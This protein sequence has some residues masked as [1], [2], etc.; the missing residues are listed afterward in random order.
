MNILFT[1]QNESLRMFDALR[2]AIAAKRSIHRVGF[3]VADRAFYEEWLRDR[4]DF[5]RRGHCLL[6]EWEVTAARDETPDLDRLAR[7]E[8]DLGAEAGLFGALVADRRLFMGSDCSFTQDYRRR[9]SDRQ[10][11]AIL[12][13]GLI[14]TERLFDELKPDVL[15]GFICVTMLDYLAYLFARQRGIRVLNLRPTRIANR[16]TFGSILNDPTPEFVAAIARAREGGSRFAEDAK[17]HIA[18]V[19]EQHG[20]YEGVIRPSKGP[21]LKVNRSGQAPLT[22][23]LRVVRNYLNYLSS[24]ARLDNHVPDPMRAMLYAA[25]I[26]PCRARRTA[27]ALGQHYTSLE[28]LSGSRYAFFPLHTEPEVSLLVYGRPFVNQ[29]ELVRQIAISLPVDMVLVVKEH[30][31]MVGKRPLASYR[32]LLN[33]PRVRLVRPELEARDLIHGASLVTVITGSVALEAAILGI[34][35]VTFGDCPYNALP[36]HLVQ[37]C[38]DL[39]SMPVLLA[40]MAVR[41]SIDDAELEAYVAAVFETSVGVNLY[42]GLLGKLGAHADRRTAYNEDIDRLASYALECLTP[43]AA[44]S[45]AAARW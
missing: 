5:E 44:R 17:R 10:L 6:K 38:A 33:I 35:V 9:F 27:R 34:P 15:V 32:E 26:N 30:P 19:R 28:A 41:R 8:R 2:G 40:Q 39:R 22:A 43:V 18:R 12:Q 11:L 36:S 4:P 13:R 7:Y 42:T 1:T 45:A 37:R 23:V 25:A 3:T 24:P 14:D 16:V 31:W 21:A 29:L 20:R